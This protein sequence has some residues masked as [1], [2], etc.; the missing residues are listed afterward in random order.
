MIIT[1]SCQTGPKF[2]RFPRPI[3]VNTGSNHTSESPKS[4][5]IRTP[6]LSFITF[7][8]KCLS[9]LLLYSQN[10]PSL[11]LFKH[12]FHCPKQ[13]KSREKIIMGTSKSLFFFFLVAFLS[14]SAVTVLAENNEEA[15]SSDP[16]LVMNF[17]K[18][19]CP[20]A[21]D[22]IKEQ[23][24]LLYKRHKNTAFSWLR[25]IFHDCAVQVH[26]SHIHTYVYI[27][28][29]LFVSSNGLIYIYIY[30]YC[31]YSHATH[32]CCWTQ[33]GGLCLRRKWT[34]ALG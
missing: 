27:I 10:Y 17:Y 9:L 15:T 18:D 1:N 11:P 4:I 20:Q 33:Q 2:A 31:M 16:G 29:V 34:E 24:K 5:K 21:E 19:T 3:S 22:I 30:I 32:L 13:S 8:A 6:K 14:L 26:K 7:H 23:V 25:N 28:L 12:H